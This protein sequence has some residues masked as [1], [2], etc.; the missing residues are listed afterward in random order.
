MI[1]KIAYTYVT[2]G[3]VSVEASSLEEAKE[4][5]YEA[6]W[7]PDREFMD[8]ETFEIDDEKTNSLNLLKK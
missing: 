4:L 7:H 1:Y 6:S 2:H 8:D 5:S 3:E